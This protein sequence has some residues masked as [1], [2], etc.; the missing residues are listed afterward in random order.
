M[1]TP[2][3]TFSQIL[4]TVRRRLRLLVIPP[5][6]VTVLCIVGAYMLPRA[7]ESTIRILVQRTDVPNP[8]ATL[9]DAMTQ[10]DDNPLRSFESIIFSQRTYEAM[11]DSLHFSETIKTEGDRRVVMARISKSIQLKMYERES[12][13]ITYEDSDPRRAQRGATVLASIFINTVTN[14]RN[15]RNEYTVEF[16]QGKLDEYRLKME[17]SQGRLV[18]RIKQQSPSSQNLNASL[19][20]QIDQADQKIKETQAR[21]K[22]LQRIAGMLHSLPD[23]MSTD[24]AKR[25]LFEIQRSEVPYATDLRPM[26]TTFEDVTTRYTSRHPEVL[27][28][29]TKIREVLER[30]DVAIAADVSKKSADLEEIRKSK[31]ELVDQLLRT[32]KVQ[33]SEDGVESDYQLYQRLHNEMK[34]KLEEAQITKVLGSNLQSQYIVM[35]KALLPLAPSKP[36][37]TMIIVGGFFLGV[38]L[39][40]V[41]AILAEFMDTT[42]RSARSIEVYRKP[43]IAY[44]PEGKELKN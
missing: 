31:A 7:Y 40:I 29:E 19:Y 34:L 1:Y 23:E 13:S 36:S 38:F 42:I 18:S 44:L 26:L 20:I 2:Q 35:D 17:E 15:D 24:E 21:L 9:A 3:I 27:K 39:G 6:A 30:M 43:V 37:R 5:L 14:V 16:Y 28:A 4:V 8:L 22:E 25:T 41:S 10:R 33:K 11:M 32:S 12:F